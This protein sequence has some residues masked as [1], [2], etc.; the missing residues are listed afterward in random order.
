MHRLLTV[1]LTALL[2]PLRSPAQAPS[3]H[4]QSAAVAAVKAAAAL[5]PTASS[6]GV[7]FDRVP[8]LSGFSLELQSSLVSRS[9]GARGFA[10]RE[11]ELTGERCKTPTCQRARQ[12]PRLVLVGWD[13]TYV[14]RRDV[15]FVAISEQ[16]QSS[17]GYPVIRVRM[18]RDGNAWQVTEAKV[19][20]P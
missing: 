4:D 19:E 2:V 1:L 16:W 11:A 8:T 12:S 20:R 6:I 5:L 13:E 10:Y 15:S 17:T 3:E 18:T 9:L 14:I 7:S